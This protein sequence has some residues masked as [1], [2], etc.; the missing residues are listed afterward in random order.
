MVM[1]RVVGIDRSGREM[2]LSPDESIAG[3]IEVN[4][5]RLTDVLAGM[6][7]RSVREIPSR[8]TRSLA[9]RRR[10]PENMT[11]EIKDLRQPRTAKKNNQMPEVKYPVGS[12]RDWSRG[13]SWLPQHLLEIIEFISFGDRFD[14]KYALGQSEK[15]K[16]Q[17]GTIKLSHFPSDKKGIHLKLEINGR[18]FGAFDEVSTLQLVRLE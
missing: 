16:E 4:P 11:Y 2:S 3:V 14:I 17:S 6:Q 15:L 13:S 5:A 9:E 10:R 18:D 7:I 12:Q 1:A 8:V